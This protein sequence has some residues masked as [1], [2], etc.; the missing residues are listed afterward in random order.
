MDAQHSS[1]EKPRRRQFLPLHFVS[2]RKSRQ[3]A[4]LKPMFVPARSTLSRVTARPVN[5]KGSIPLPMFQFLEP[6][7][8][9][10][11]YLPQVSGV[12]PPPIDRLNA[13]TSRSIS[14]LYSLF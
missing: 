14:A 12:I 13:G 8:P 6:P 10:T 9:S 5:S 7:N 3:L 11:H 2:V 1:D 4:A